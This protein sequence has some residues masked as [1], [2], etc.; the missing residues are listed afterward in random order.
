MKNEK[1]KKYLQDCLTNSGK[2][3]NPNSELKFAYYGFNIKEDEGLSRLSL[4]LDG[5]DGIFILFL[6]LSNVVFIARKCGHE[7]IVEEMIVGD[8]D[9]DNDLEVF[10]CLFKA[11]KNDERLL[12]N[13]ELIRSENYEFPS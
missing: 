8:F 5:N 10:I 13:L 4:T 12:A 7:N 3:F 6:P 2:S 9:F 1:L 11:P